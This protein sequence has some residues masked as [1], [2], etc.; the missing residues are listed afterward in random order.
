MVHAV[1]V[2]SVMVENI[3]LFPFREETFAVEVVSVLSCIV[4]N[5]PLFPFS[6]ET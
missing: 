1:S 5:I 2:L 6:V 4:E 3:P